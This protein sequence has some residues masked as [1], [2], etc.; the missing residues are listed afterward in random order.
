M[1]SPLTPEQKAAL[2]DEFAKSALPLAYAQCN[3]A[4]IQSGWRPVAQLA[5]AIADWMLVARDE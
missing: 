2:R 3:A 1:N 4:A 5:Y